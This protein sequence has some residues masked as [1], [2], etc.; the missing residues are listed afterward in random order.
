MI[1]PMSVFIYLYNFNARI[2]RQKELTEM[3]C[4]SSNNY[5]LMHA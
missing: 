3:F 1:K 4:F 2:I 5:V